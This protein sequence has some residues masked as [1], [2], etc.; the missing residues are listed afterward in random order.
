MSQISVIISTYNSSRFILETLESIRNQSWSDIELIITDDYST[1]N[2]LDICRKWIETN[3]NR[4]CSFHLLTTERNTGI[5]A[6]ANRGLKVATGEWVK[7]L[8]AD[9]T[10]LPDC[11]SDNIIYVKN[12]PE[13]TVLF[14]K[15]NIYRNDFSEENYLLTIPNQEIMPESILWPVRTAESQ[16]RMLL[17][18]DRIDFS[19]S[20]FISRDILN[21]IGGFDER[22]RILEDYPLWL[23][24]T[25]AGH[26]L[27]FM[28]KK[29]VNYRQHH[30]AINNTGKSFVINP[31]YFRSE[32]FRKTY[33][34]PQLPLL[35]R[36]KQRFQWVMSQVFR[37]EFLNR[38][39][40][41]TNI[42]YRTLIYY[43]NP[44]MY[45]IKIR[46]LFK[47]NESHREFYL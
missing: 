2:T 31:N 8:G 28:D 16:Y 40:R 27:F 1:D 4:F 37:I 3:A 36:S 14:S 30:S 19:P 43:L 39:T 18:T 42:L 15:I 10:L 21:E 26:K 9:D 29:T 24:L 35:I 12:N 6:N 44:F 34:Y 47:I 22:F 17:V 23:N 13:V 41:F 7:F 33:T 32:S 46:K 45:F 11:I 25:R 20:I 38:Y 5:S